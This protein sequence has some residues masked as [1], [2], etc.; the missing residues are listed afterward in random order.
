IH[1]VS[2]T[3]DVSV[4][5]FDSDPATLGRPSSTPPGQWL[6]NHAPSNVHF[7]PSASGDR[8]HKLPLYQ[9]AD[10]NVLLD[11]DIIEGA[12]PVGSISNGFLATDLASPSTHIDVWITSSATERTVSCENLTTCVTAPTV[13]SDSSFLFPTSSPSPSI[14]CAAT[15]KLEETTARPFSAP[16]RLVEEACDPIS[17][18]F[19]DGS[20]LSFT[21]LDSATLVAEESDVNGAY[22]PKST[23]E[24]LVASN[25]PLLFFPTGYSLDTDQD[26]VPLCD[27]LS[28]SSAKS[29][30]SPVDSYEAG[31]NNYTVDPELNNPDYMVT[32][33]S[34]IL[35]GNS[36]NSVS[37]SRSLASVDLCETVPK[38]SDSQGS[39][40]TTLSEFGVSSKTY[41][42]APGSITTHLSAFVEAM[43]SY[44]AELCPVDCVILMERCRPFN[45]DTLFMKY[46]REQYLCPIL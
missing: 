44:A 36:A 16:K 13:P 26:A 39:P 7:T 45:C 5:V 27:F 46:F 1:R 38:S 35:N 41:L 18:L 22:P 10:Y 15:D 34:D 8:V 23:L 28:A 3:N 40:N 37:S 2:D 4:R 33:G 6:L 14:P 17:E 21:T 24:A 42:D 32:D 12:Q 30:P 20:T 11:S 9:E 31:E 25:S 29:R 19:V 43:R